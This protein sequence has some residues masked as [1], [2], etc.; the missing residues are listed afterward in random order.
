[1]VVG[2]KVVEGF[3][4]GRVVVVVGR[5]VV[6]VVVVDS[7]VVVVVVGRVVVVVVVV[8]VVGNLVVAVVMVDDFVV[9]V[10]VGGAEFTALIVDIFAVVCWDVLFVVIVDENDGTGV[11]SLVPSGLVLG[12]KEGPSIALS[13]AVNALA[14][15]MLTLSSIIINVIEDD[16]LLPIQQLT[17]I[18]NVSCKVQ[19]PN[20]GFS[21]PFYIKVINY[22]LRLVVRNVCRI[23]RV[24]Q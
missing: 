17:L 23:L 4:V 6:V 18:L 1:M 8:V 16:H 22:S 5:V 13:E 19:I 20:I 7:V 10:V 15:C 24:V 2:A 14:P 9:V 11:I 12:F 21:L 3:V